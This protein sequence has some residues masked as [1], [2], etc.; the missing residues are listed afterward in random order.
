[1][2]QIPGYSHLATMVES[3]DGGIEASLLV[4]RLI[5]TPLYFLSPLVKKKSLRLKVWLGWNFEGGKSG[6][7][8][9]SIIRNHDIPIICLSRRRSRLMVHCSDGGDVFPVQSPL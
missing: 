5:R 2:T 4:G 7:E 8:Q 1:M 9:K 6:T 3:G